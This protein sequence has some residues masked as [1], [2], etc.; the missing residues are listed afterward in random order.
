MFFF[1]FL[2]V[3]VGKEE[4][5]NFLFKEKFTLNMESQ[6]E[7]VHFIKD[8]SWNIF[9]LLILTSPLSDTC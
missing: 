1:P 2:K 6:R 7:V 5:L 9:F 4:K 8:G 3:G